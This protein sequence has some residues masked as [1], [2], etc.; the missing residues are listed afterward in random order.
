MSFLPC[1]AC[2]AKLKIDGKKHQKCRQSKRG[3]AGAPPRYSSDKSS[4]NHF[5]VPDF[6]KP[7]EEAG[8]FPGLLMNNKI[9]TNI[10]RI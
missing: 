7:C 8:P 3:Q 9:L 6:W 2:A 10:E 4:P 5:N 1:P